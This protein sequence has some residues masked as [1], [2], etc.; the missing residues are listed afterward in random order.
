MFKGFKQFILRGNAI[1][2]AVGV[3][4][5]AAFNSIVS[6]LVKG[7]L[8]PLIG[9]IAKLPD[10]SAWAFTIRGSKFLIGDVVNSAV[11]FLLTALAVYFF[12]VVPM[13]KFKK[14]A[15]STTKLC[16][17]CKSEISIDAKRCA[18]CTQ[19]VV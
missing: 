1:D 8:T 17:E 12:V 13:N 7:L 15:V 3:V 5:G 6:S 9:V 14:P 10:F 2:L 16:P 4:I 19:T 11:S 18:H